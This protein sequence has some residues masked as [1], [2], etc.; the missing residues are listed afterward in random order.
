[1]LLV[2]AYVVAAVLLIIGAIFLF[3]LTGRWL[4]RIIG[5]REAAVRAAYKAGWDRAIDTA[6]PVLFR[7]GEQHADAVWREW[8]SRNFPDDSNGVAGSA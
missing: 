2:V 5:S 1:M 3:R 7:A 6:G 4:D 8:H